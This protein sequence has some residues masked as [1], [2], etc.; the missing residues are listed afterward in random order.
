[1]P[2]PAVRRRSA[3]LLAPAGR[4]IASAAAVAGLLAAPAVAQ[5]PA[6]GASA[7]V[8]IVLD[9]S[10]SMWGQ[11]DGIA[12]IEI[13]REVVGDLVRGWEPDRTLGLVA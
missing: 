2:S 12:K 9:A 13:A 7:D 6:A 1:M 11:I 4:R 8:M 5:E 3:S 10:N